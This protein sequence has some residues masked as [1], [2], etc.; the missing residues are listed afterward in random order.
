MNKAA[1]PL[2]PEFTERQL[3]YVLFEELDLPEKSRFIVAYSGGRDSQ[4]LLYAMSV[5]GQ[6]RG[7]S[8]L[9]AHFDHGLHENSASWEQKCHGWAE[10]FGVEFCSTRQVIKPRKGENTEAEARHARYRWLHSISATGDVVLTAHHEDDQAETFL[11]HLFSGKHLAQLAGIAR[12]RPLVH[13]SRINLVRPF[14]GFSRN[15]IADYA[16]RNE[17]QWVDDPSNQSLDYYRNFLRHELIPVLSSRNT[18]NRDLLIRGVKACGRLAGQEQKTNMGLVRSVS[19]PRRRGIYCVAEPLFLA[20]KFPLDQY[21]FSSLVRFWA[22]SAGVK[23]PSNRQLDDFHR[24]LVSNQSGYAQ[25][26]AGNH[27]IRFY[28]E[29]IFLT[30]EICPASTPV[31]WDFEMLK[32]N[33]IGLA[34]MPQQQP[35]GLDPELV[36]HPNPP[37]FHWRSGGERFTLPGRAHSTPLKKLFQQFR[38]PPWERNSIP[39]LYSGNQIIWAHGIGCA[40]GFTCKTD[41]SGIIPKISLLAD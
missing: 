6:K 2:K 30:R 8:L 13:G 19:R 39:Y 21:G 33:E 22:H 31:S 20:G 37:E 4:A 10:Q 27:L 9:A 32:M 7:L 17:L 41:E 1:N 35:G 34:V 23:S 3:E 36:R 38:V 16:R 29:H 15:Q 12:I 28:D 14:L 40:S 5:L 18:V 24:Q 25:I 11:L 26:S